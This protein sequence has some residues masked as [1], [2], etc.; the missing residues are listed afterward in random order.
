[1]IIGHIFLK[2][3]QKK[4][5]NKNIWK[6]YATKYGKPEEYTTWP[7]MIGVFYIWNQYYSY[8]GGSL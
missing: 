1:M 3:W 6:Q 8:R 7:Y 4:P 5:N 2:I